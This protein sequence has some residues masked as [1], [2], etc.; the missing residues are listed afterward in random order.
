VLK[1]C[2]KKTLFDNDYPIIIIGVINKSFQS[3]S[4][5]KNSNYLWKLH[6]DE[7]PYVKFVL[8]MKIYLGI[9]IRM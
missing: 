3:I 7:N 9:Y 6:T 2:K 1:N 4:T 5:K 8:Y